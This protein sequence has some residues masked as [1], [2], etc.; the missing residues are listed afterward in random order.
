MVKKYIIYGAGKYGIGLYGFLDLTGKVDY[1]EAFCDKKYSDIQDVDGKP[2]LS[3]EEARNLNIPFILAVSH[4]NKDLY[5]EV[6]NMFTTDGAQFEDISAFIDGIYNEYEKRREFEKYMKLDPRPVEFYRIKKLLQHESTT[7]HSDSGIKYVWFMPQFPF[8]EMIFES[9]KERKDTIVVESWE[10][11]ILT[12]QLSNE[13]KYIFIVFMPWVR[14][15][16]D[17]IQ[18]MR[19]LFAYSYFVMYS[20]DTKVL[21]ENTYD[22]NNVFDAVFSYDED[23]ARRIGVSFYPGLYDKSS[24]YTD[25]EKEYDIVWSGRSYGRFDELIKVYDTAT[26]IGLKCHFIVVDDGSFI[27]A[28]K[29]GIEYVNTLTPE[30]SIRL[31][32][33]GRCSL[34][35]KHND[36]NALTI[37]FYEAITYGMKFLTNNPAVMKSKYFNPQMMQYFSEPDKI[38]F[39]FLLDNKVY[40]YNY[41]GEFSTDYFLKTLD[42]Q[43]LLNKR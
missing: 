16:F 42:E 40:D 35:L 41:G 9:V 33:S 17:L 10:D 34:E 37:R 28:D 7:P 25:K 26:G 30:E 14:R 27:R 20:Y 36:D 4:D 13:K 24:I 32:E 6:V 2:C 39:S 29:Q 1:I 21:R 11:V 12:T 18:P 3:Y 43:F 5:D 23:E 38:D 19:R 31:T 15:L 8:L 22:Y